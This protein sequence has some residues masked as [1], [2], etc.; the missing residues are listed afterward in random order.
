MLLFDQHG[1]VIYHFTIGM[2]TN[3]DSPHLSSTKVE[4]SYSTAA[5]KWARPLMPNRRDFYCLIPELVVM[6]LAGSFIIRILS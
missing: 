3:T 1:T 2:L 4:L 5:I 6:D